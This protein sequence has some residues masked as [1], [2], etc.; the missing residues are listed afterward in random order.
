MAKKVT[1]MSQRQ[2]S[3]GRRCSS[4][5]DSHARITHANTSQTAVMKRKSVVPGAVVMRVLSTYA[6]FSEMR[7]SA[8][9]ERMPADPSFVQ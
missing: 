4:W 6:V 9:I 7:F 3:S 5:Y 1:A 8:P 2:L